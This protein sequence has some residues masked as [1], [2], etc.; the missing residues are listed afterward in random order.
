M[1]LQEIH[2]SAFTLLTT[3]TQISGIASEKLTELS[4]P[5]PTMSFMED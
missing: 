2:T 1:T 3:D 4:N 5:I